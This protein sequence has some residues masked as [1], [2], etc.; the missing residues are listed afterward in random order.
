[1][2]QER[3]K[4]RVARSTVHTG[5]AGSF[6]GGREMSKTTLRRFMAAGI[7]AAVLAMAVAGPAQA[8]GLAP[9]P[10]AESWL[11]GLWMKGVSVLWSWTEAWGAEPGAGEPADPSKQGHGT[12]PN[13]GPGL[14]P[15]EPTCTSC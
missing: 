6:E 5:P 2:G 11:H 10:R 13:G 9:A 1:M 15:T 8:R 12:D 14:A 4:L 7:L 3:P